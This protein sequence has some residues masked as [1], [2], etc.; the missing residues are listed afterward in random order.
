MNRKDLCIYVY[1]NLGVYRMLYGCIIYCKGWKIM[2][3]K[4]KEMV[5]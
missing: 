4:F 2:R 1:M 5:I 3:G